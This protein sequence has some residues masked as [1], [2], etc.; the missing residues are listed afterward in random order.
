MIKL[1]HSQTEGRLKVCAY[2][3]ISNDKAESE[4]SLIEQISFYSNLILSN[5]NWEFAGIFADEGISGTSKKK[6]DQFNSMIQKA[7]DGQIDVILVKSISRYARNVIDLL[8]SIRELRQKG[9]EVYFEKEGLSSL[10]YKSDQMLTVYAKFAEEEAISMSKNVLWSYEKDRNRGIYRFPSLLF[11]YYTDGEGNIKVNESQ[12]KWVRVI[13]DMYL[14]GKSGDEIVSY[15]EANKVKT[16]TGK[17]KWSHGSVIRIL[18]NEKYCGDALLQ[19]KYIADTLTHKKV[20]NLGEKEQVLV[21]NGHT[22]I[23]DRDTWNRAQ[24]LRA[25]RCAHFKARKG[26]RSE[27][28]ID[29]TYTGFARCPYCGQTYTQKTQRHNGKV[30]RKFLIDTSNRSGTV[31]KQSETV[32]CD[33]LEKVI[34]DEIKFLKENASFLKKALIEGFTDDA[35]E[36][37][38]NQINELNSQIEDLKSQYEE[39]AGN[40]DEFSSEVKKGIKE[41]INRLI[42]DKALIENEMITSRS[43]ESRAQEVLAALKEMP[44][45]PE[46]IKDV[47][48]RTIFSTMIVRKKN[49]LIFVIGNPDISKIS[50]RAKPLLVRHLSYRIR[51]TDY[52]TS[53]GIV[54]NK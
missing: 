16:A 11:G 48:F 33:I 22:A 28:V 8:E 50:L 4:G 38:L 1:L 3:R 44:D 15:L 45:S 40:N 32:F 41:R 29:T 30:D 47:K 6:R 5:Q 43:P 53:Y 13:F 34:L 20:K 12:A 46:S 39:L 7:K 25:Q 26:I 10:D 17:A 35:L 2:A 21:M 54:I 14:E 52:T 24:E 49:D 31:C 27:G 18:T 9:V 36:K 51:K 37:K 42:N 19:K 23:V